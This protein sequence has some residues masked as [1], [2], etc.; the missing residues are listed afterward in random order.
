[1]SR[2]E[3]LKELEQEYHGFMETKEGQKWKTE[4]QVEHLLEDREDFGDFGDYLYD[5]YS[6]MLL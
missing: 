1:M 2:D 5:F 4:W 3:K 6:E